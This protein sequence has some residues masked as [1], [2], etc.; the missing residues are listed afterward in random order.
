M[1]LKEKIALAEEESNDLEKVEQAKKD[2]ARVSAKVSMEYGHPFNRQ[3]IVWNF[4]EK[5][6]FDS[7]PLCKKT[8]QHEHEVGMLDLI[9]L[10]IRVQWR[11]LKKRFS[12]RND[13]DN[14]FLLE[15]LFACFLILFILSIK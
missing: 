2:F 9:F 3:E 11:K 1:N 15:I 12:K 7:C 5:S 8:T 14:I 4:L 6:E 10:A 13:Q